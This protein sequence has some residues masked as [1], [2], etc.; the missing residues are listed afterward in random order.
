MK[1]IFPENNATLTEENRR[2]PGFV[3]AALGIVFGDIGT[4]PL[5]A[6]RECFLGIHGPQINTANI[7]GVLSIII[8]A[9]L[10]VISLKYL[11]FVLRA[12]NRGEG[13]I[14]ALMALVVRGEKANSRRQSVMILLGL[15]GAALLYGDSMITP[16]ISVLSAVEGLRK[17]SPAFDPYLVP[18]AIFVLLGLFYYQ[19]QGTARI[20][21]LFGP[22]VLVWFA[23]LAITGIRSIW[24]E[25][26]VLRAFNPL[27]AIHFFVSNGWHGF[28][29]MGTVFLVVT[30]GEALYADMGHVGRRPIRIGWF[31][32][33]LPA[34]LLNY[35]GQGALLIR[36]SDSLPDLFFALVPSWALYPMI[37][38]A[39]VATIIA[40]QAVLSGAFSLTQQAVQLG[41]LPRMTIVHTSDEEYGQVYVPMTNWALF[42]GAVGLVL[43]FQ[44]SGG[45][46]HA[47]G[48]AVTTTMLITTV[49]MYFAAIKLWQWSI[50]ATVIMT[51]GFLVIDLSFFGSNIVKVFSGGWIPL[52]IAGIVYV[53]LVTW[54]TGRSILLKQVGQHSISVEAFIDEVK[55]SKPTRIPGLAVFMTGHASGVPET[56]LHNYKHNKVLHEQLILVTV[57][58]V[59]QPRVPKSERTELAHLGCG[60]YRATFRFGFSEQPDVP[61]AL[62]GIDSNIIDFKVANTTFFLGR[63]TLLVDQRQ[64]GNMW[65]WQRRLFAFASRTSPDATRFFKIP[66]NRTI[67]IGVQIQL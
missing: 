16:A 27:H 61:A 52:L 4:S 56:L 35:L 19:H 5:Y 65:H 8:W 55:Q 22:V 42:V 17:A 32:L 51:C 62:R 54:K 2:L 10:L 31:L 26:G 24:Y 33:V 20:G 9:L 40:S 67:E 49:L 25:P 34:L 63:E 58:T 47:Y 36:S 53:F 64:K 60:F 13:G 57:Q 43:T 37:L 21:K 38:L 59:E 6:F 48:V 11:V 23:V 29:V 45:L 1:R 44:A 46:A 12:D 66:P 3:L 15:F 18:I 41:Y 28:A 14:L 7:L 30:G 50:P 39:M